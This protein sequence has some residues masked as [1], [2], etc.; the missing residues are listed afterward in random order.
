MTTTHPF[1]DR[2][3]AL[4]ADADVRIDGD[5]DWDMQVHDPHLPA[6]LVA[7]GSLKLGESYMD[8]WWDARGLDGSLSHLPEARIEDDV[9]S[10]AEIRAARRARLFNLQAGRRSYE[11]GK[12]HYDL[13][14][15]LYRAMLGKRLVYSCCYWRQAE[16]LDDAQEAKLDLICRKLGLR[17]GMRVLDIGCGWGEAL[18]FAAER[19]S[20]SGVGVTTSPEQAAFPREM[21][22]GAPV[23]TRVKDYRALD[24]RF[25]R[26]FPVGMFEHVGL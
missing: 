16:N 25:D 21:L 15:D 18:K 4:L 20:V 6:R 23:E 9:P 22:A 12:R 13:G 5:R 1:R 2:L 7:G 24:E 11:V 10:P 17:E 3:Q 14:N 26:I 8:G 19:Y